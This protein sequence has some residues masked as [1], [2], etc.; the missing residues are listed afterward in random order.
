MLEAGKMGI[1]DLTDLDKGQ[2]VMDRQLQNGPQRSVP[3]KNGARKEK[4]I[5]ACGEGRLA[6]LVRSC[7]RDTGDQIAEKVVAGSDR[8]VSEHTVH[9]QWLNK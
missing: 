5:D 1:Q 2:I 6:H 8:K 9:T 4:L 7:R 3:I